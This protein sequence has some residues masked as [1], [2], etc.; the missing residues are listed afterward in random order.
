MTEAQIR[1]IPVC[2]RPFGVVKCGA[3]GRDVR[4][5]GEHKRSDNTEVP[6]IASRTLVEGVFLPSC[7]E[8]C[9]GTLRARIGTAGRIPK[10]SYLR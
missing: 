7:S 8:V 1:A 10:R 2:S 6:L 5:L 3:C 4:R 9:L